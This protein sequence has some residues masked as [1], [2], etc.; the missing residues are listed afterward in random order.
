MASLPERP[1]ALDRIHTIMTELAHTT[2]G[3]LVQTKS[4]GEALRS[5]GASHFALVDR[6][7]PLAL[8]CVPWSASR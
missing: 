7:G 8:S 1:D 5:G 6:A 3:P 2:P 4:P